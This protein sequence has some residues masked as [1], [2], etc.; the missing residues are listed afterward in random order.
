MVSGTVPGDVVAVVFRVSVEVCAVASMITT[1]GGLK[2]ALES[3]GTPPIDRS[4]LPLNP[5]RGV[6]VTV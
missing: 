2:L 3:S 1:V 4:T 5:P 6:T